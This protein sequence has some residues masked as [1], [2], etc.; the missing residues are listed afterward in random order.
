MSVPRDTDDFGEANPRFVGVEDGGR[1]V[2]ASKA[3]TGGVYGVCL[4]LQDPFLVC[5][6]RIGCVS[7]LPMLDPGEGSVGHHWPQQAAG[8]G[9]GHGAG[10]VFRKDKGHQNGGSNR[11]DWDPV[12]E[13][14]AF[15][16]LEEE[17][18]I[19]D[20]DDGGKTIHDACTRKRLKRWKGWGRGNNPL[21]MYITIIS[22]HQQN[23]SLPVTCASTRLTGL[24]LWCR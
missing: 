19:V 15:F 22:K 18:G 9:E 10:G 8:G 1:W 3:E 21:I 11:S 7:S 6:V 17:V 12:E 14:P 2:M 5:H 23:A 4:W 13:L 24:A 20:D 16:L